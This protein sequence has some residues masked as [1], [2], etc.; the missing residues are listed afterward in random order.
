MAKKKRIWKKDCCAHK[1]FVGGISASG[2]KR[3]FYNYCVPYSFFAEISVFSRRRF[4]IVTK[5]IIMD[6]LLINKAMK[7]P[8]IQRVALA[9]LLLASIDY[10]EEEI[11][12]AWVS[13]VNE[14]MNAVNEGRSTLLDFDALFQ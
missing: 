13:E 5:E 4:S 1:T 12:E 14:R 3:Y 8:P 2:L 7:M 11:C 6:K 10:E 9:E